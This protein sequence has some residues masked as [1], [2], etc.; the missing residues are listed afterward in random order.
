MA[1]YWKS[2][3]N[4][5]RCL[6]HQCDEAVSEE[7]EIE[8]YPGPVPAVEDVL[9]ESSKGSKYDAGKP[10]FSLIPVSLIMDAYFKA[11]NGSDSLQR[12][13]TGC[14]TIINMEGEAVHATAIRHLMEVA[15]E[16]L[17]LECACESMAY[18]AVK[19]GR[20]NWKDGFGG[21][22][23]RFLEATIRH[24]LALSQGYEHDGE[25]IKGF[26]CGNNHKGAIYFSLMVAY[27]EIV[28]KF[29]GSPVWSN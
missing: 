25:S 16:G 2:V 6:R 4:C 12:I 22:Y 7:Q 19:Y 24:C 28:R 26:P 13:V 23:K 11:H 5:A 15:R 14:H 1:C 29:S 27:N 10:Q 17:G 18:G 9:E 8:E 20:D 21:D 3:S